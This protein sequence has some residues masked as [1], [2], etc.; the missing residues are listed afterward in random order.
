V[1]ELI[2]TFTNGNIEDSKNTVTKIQKKAH[3]CMHLSKNNG[4]LMRKFS[5]ES[6]STRY[7]GEIMQQSSRKITSLSRFLDPTLLCELLRWRL[8]SC[9]DLPAP[10]LRKKLSRTLSKC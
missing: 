6:I 1:A 10:L 9:S 3:K 2:C 4:N 8:Y 7:Y 5:D